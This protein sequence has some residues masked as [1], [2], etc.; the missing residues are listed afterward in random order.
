M[1]L[2]TSIDLMRE[3]RPFL[4][5][6][7][8][9]PGVDKLLQWVAR[10]MVIGQP[11]SQLR[12]GIVDSPLKWQQ[13]RQLRLETYRDKLP[14]MLDVINPDGSDAY[15][16]RSIIYGA[17][18][19]DKAI[20]TLRC[21]SGPFE[22]TQYL[23]PETI[24]SVLPCERARHTLELSRLISQSDTP[25]KRVMP[26]L[27][28]FAGISV[29]L[30]TDF[31]HYIGYSKPKIFKKFDEFRDGEE[32]AQFTIPDRGDHVYEVVSGSFRGDFERFLAQRIKSQRLTRLITNAVAK[33]A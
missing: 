2:P 18:F 6:P 29:C 20:A 16:A 19:Q 9:R 10:S 23:S 7:I 22:I 5:A 32:H 14:Y 3:R 21:T 4:Q 30:F 26:A 12:F 1:I 17:W 24:A 8:V 15:D 33:P 27:V 31:E 13:I 25:F 28:A 11:R